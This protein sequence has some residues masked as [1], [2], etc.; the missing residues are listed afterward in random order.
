MIEF[1]ELENGKLRLTFF[2]EAAREEI[3]EMIDKHGEMS[4]LYDATESYWANG[5]GVTSADRLWQMSEAPV[6][7]EDYTVEDDGSV[8]LYGKAWYFSNYM[9]E[10]AIET[11]LEKGYVDFDF[12]QTFDEER[13]PE[14]RG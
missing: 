7:V 11:M 1:N 10:S 8:T 3:A 12:W 14:Y 4:I 9:I 2:N 5:W 6:I 13:F